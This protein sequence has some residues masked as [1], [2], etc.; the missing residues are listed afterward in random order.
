MEGDEVELMD[1]ETLGV[2]IEGLTIGQ[3]KKLKL[4]YQNMTADMDLKEL[5]KRT[6]HF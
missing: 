5:D 1:L 2:E 4:Y 6:E 3:I